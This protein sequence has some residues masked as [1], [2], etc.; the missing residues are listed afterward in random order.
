MSSDK[1]EFEKLVAETLAAIAEPAP[2]DPNNPKTS[3]RERFYEFIAIVLGN[4]FAKSPV[5]GTLYDRTT[6]LRVIVGL[7]DGDAASLAKRTDDWLR[8]EGLI[9]QQEGQR[10]YFLPLQTMAALSVITEHGM[11]GD[12]LDRVLQRYNQSMPSE[13]LRRC[14]RLLAAEFIMR[15]AHV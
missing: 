10:S 9:R 14:T 15:Y 8:L 7:D 6:M 4:L 3:M 5:A 12:V 13:N 11:L 1:N 2:E